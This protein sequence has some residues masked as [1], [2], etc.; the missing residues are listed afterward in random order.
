[1]RGAAMT[2]RA[3]KLPWRELVLGVAGEHC[4]RVDLEIRGEAP[5]CKCQALPARIIL[6]TVLRAIDRTGRIPDPA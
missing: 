2:R 5:A 6:A 4:H 1:M 3:P